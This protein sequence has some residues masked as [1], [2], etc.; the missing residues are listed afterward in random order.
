MKEPDN[1]YFRHTITLTK[2]TK[3]LMKK[4]IKIFKNINQILWHEES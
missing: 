3:M 1:N 4:I 2:L